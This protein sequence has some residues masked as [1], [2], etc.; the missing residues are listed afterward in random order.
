M[1]IPKCANASY[2]IINGPE[3]TWT[4][5]NYLCKK[6]KIKNTVINVLVIVREY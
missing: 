3:L 4:D 6:T 1:L 2:L 5:V